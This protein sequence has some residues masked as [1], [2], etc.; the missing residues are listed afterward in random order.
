[1][2]FPLLSKTRYLD[3]PL[4]PL[5][6]SS[7]ALWASVVW[8]APPTPLPSLCSWECTGPIALLTPCSPP[9]EMGSAWPVYG[10][11]G[12]GF[13]SPRTGALGVGLEICLLNACLSEL[14]PWVWRS[15]WEVTCHSQQAGRNFSTC[16]LPGLLQF[17][18]VGPLLTCWALFSVMVV[19][20]GNFHEETDTKQEEIKQGAW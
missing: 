13:C 3:K 12:L 6:T 17:P 8:G 18:G 19:T 9:E 20:D 4:G 15:F 16:A 1:M 14:A 5:G 11:A 2:L 7:S 10:R